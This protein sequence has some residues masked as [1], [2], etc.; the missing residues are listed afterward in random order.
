V[1]ADTWAAV[2][3]IGTLAA[4]WLAVR[5]SEENRAL[6]QILCAP[7]DTTPEDDEQ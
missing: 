6:R 4:S 7:I 2:A 1:T 3:A 5:W